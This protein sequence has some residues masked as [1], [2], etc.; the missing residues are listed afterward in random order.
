MDNVKYC[1]YGV[2]IYRTRN[3]NVMQTCGVQKSACVQVSAMK[4]KCFMFN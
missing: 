3:G 2:R 4:G 1:T